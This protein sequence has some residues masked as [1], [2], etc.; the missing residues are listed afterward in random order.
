MADGDDLPDGSGTTRLRETLAQL[1]LRE[2]LRGV[3][4]RIDEVINAR[5]RMDGLLEA[6]LA[7]A[8][9]LELDATLRRIVHA[10]IDLVD[11]RYGALGVL[12]PDGNGLAEFIYEGIGEQTRGLIGDLPSGHGLLG[13]L[14]EQPK[15]VRLDVLSNHP[16]SAGFPEH[17][18]PM[19]TFLGV[20]VRVRDKVFGDLYLTEKVG[21]QGFTEDDEV[22]VQALAAAAGIAIENARLYEQ[23]QLRRR[24][25]EATSEVRVALIAAEDPAQVLDLVADRALELAGADHAFI[26]Q[27]EDP[28]QPE[29]EVTHLVITVSKG[30]DG[31]DFSGRVLPVDGSTSGAAY[32]RRTPLQVAELESDPAA[33][34]DLELGPALALPLRVAADAVSGVLVTVRESGASPFGPDQLPLAAAFTDQA[35][36]ALQLADDQRRLRELQVL[37]DRDRIARDLHDHVI[38]RLFSIGLSVQSTQQRAR[39][40]EV[41]RRLADTVSDLQNVVS[42]IRSTIFDLHGSAQSSSQLRQRLNEAVT[43]LVGDSGLH[44]TIRI[45]GPL[46]VVS[47]ELADS[48]EA[49]VRE[50]VSNA[51]RHSGAT[52][53]TI[54]ASVADD[55]VIDVTDDGAGIPGTVARSGLH[56][57]EQRAVQAGGEL[58]V[59]RP[60]A[61]GTR[62]VWS[63]PLP[64]PGR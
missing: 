28:E 18:P 2:L 48:A 19:R 34:H 61:G 49:V 24:W 6:M 63:A 47:G 11:A 52:T 7:V 22:V 15:P 25:Q 40:P 10:A 57:L 30:R 29:D 56:N 62:V 36:L 46:G 14:I 1:Q 8:S 3:Q 33:G 59:E 53:V 31:H 60:T 5:D 39:S 32:R 42:D 58:R 37:G 16:S 43:E 20:P 64:D 35:A 50:A 13:L 12:N 23:S 55:L 38:Q 21:G 41:Q 45:A 44:S 9:G 4:D 17:H 51:V 26:A 27:P 54:T